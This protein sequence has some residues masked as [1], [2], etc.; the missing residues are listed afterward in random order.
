MAPTP[1]YRGRWDGTAIV[2][3]Q[4]IFVS[5]DVDTFHSRLKFDAAGKLFATIGGPAL[6]TNASMM[7]AQKADDYAGQDPAPQR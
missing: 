1:I 3:G 7:R 6:G 5:D 2:D 4:D